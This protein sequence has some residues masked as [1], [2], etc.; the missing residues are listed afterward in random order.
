MEKGAKKF[1]KSVW[2]IAKEFEG[3]FFDSEKLLNI[4]RPDP[5]MHAT[6]FIKEQIV[7][8]QT[9]QKKGYTYV[10]END[11]V[12]F[13][14]AK[15]P[16]YFKLS[17]QNPNELKVGA[18]VDFVEGKRNVTDFALWKFSSKGEKRQMEWES[19]WGV[20]FPGW[21]IECSAMSMNALGETFD[22]HTGG[23]DHINIH[24]TN[25]IA[26]SEA[27]TSKQF[28]KYWVHH[29]F[30]MV[31]GEKMS[32]SLGNIYT[33][34]DIVKKGYDPLALRYLY[35]QTHYRQEMNFTFEAL[36]AA[37]N[38]LERLRREIANYSEDS[39]LIREYEEQFLEAINDDLNMPKALSVLWEVVRSDKKTSEKAAT[40]F[41]FDGVLGLS[42]KD[43]KTIVQKKEKIPGE[44]QKMLEEREK[45]RKAK[46]YDEADKIREK[47]IEMGYKVEDKV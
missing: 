15:F 11:G 6:D 13:D 30:L 42:L 35:L 34:Q 45:L 22:I 26:Q 1:G 46:K 21:H 3:Q 19:P 29:A 5:I 43:S 18:R 37:Q 38:A 2:D 27:A 33:V 9:L 25:E 23:V 14:T 20:G 24:H 16:D 47:I 40:V 36:S 41:K 10:I 31:E 28:V 32:K 4:I 8:I 12:Y 39:D 44:V 7:L 17:R